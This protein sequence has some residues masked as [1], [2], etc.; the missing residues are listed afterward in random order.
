VGPT[1]TAEPLPVCFHD[2]FTRRFIV[3][4]LLF[5][6]AALIPVLVGLAI[7]FF[8]PRTGKAATGGSSN[9]WKGTWH[10][11]RKCFRN[12]LGATICLGLIALYYA[13]SKRFSGPSGD[14][15][16]GFSVGLAFGSAILGIRV[17]K[18][19]FMDFL[20]QEMEEEKQPEAL[21][22]EYMGKALGRQ[23]PT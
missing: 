12:T 22:N 13:L 10:R 1:E 15:S 17:F 8:W 6:V 7:D 3:A 23:A 5:L 18:Y 11:I 4:G 21:A 9:F 16:S 2:V 19:Q 20:D 14:L